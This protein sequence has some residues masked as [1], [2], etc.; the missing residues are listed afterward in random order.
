MSDHSEPTS[1]VDPFS[2]RAIWDL[3]TLKKESRIIILTTHFM[4]EADQLGDRIGIMHKGGLKCC[5]TSLFLKRRYG[6][7]YQM[8]ITKNSVRTSTMAIMKVVH[9]LVTE[10]TLLSDIGNEVTISLPFSVSSIF[11][12]LLQT[13]DE[14]KQRLE[15][16]SYALSVTT[17]EEVFIKYVTRICQHTFTTRVLYVCIYVLILILYDGIGC[18]VLFG[19][20]WHKNK[21]ILSIR[22]VS[23]RLNVYLAITNR[24]LKHIRIIRKVVKNNMARMKHKWK[25]IH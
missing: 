22:H 14:E 12:T 24:I 21:L 7:G 11:P 2:R 9:E 25:W 20:E 23:S 8:T 17:L 16:Q 4:D 15:I 5:G 13:L 18:V 19:V 3:L 10:A 6:V 1:G